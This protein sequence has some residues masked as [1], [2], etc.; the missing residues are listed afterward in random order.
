MTILLLDPFVDDTN[1]MF[2]NFCLVPFWKKTKK[3]ILT[4]NTFKVSRNE[5][6]NTLLEEKRKKTKDDD[7]LKFFE[8][9]KSI[10]FIITYLYVYPIASA[11]YTLIIIIIIIISLENDEFFSFLND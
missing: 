11:K 7:D 3:L 10:I 9:T 4:R 5:R 2:Y 1:R 6:M 8:A